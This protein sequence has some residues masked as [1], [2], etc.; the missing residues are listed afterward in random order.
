MNIPRFVNQ[1]NSE[2]NFNEYVAPANQPT[3]SAS[4][5]AIEAS[6]DRPPCCPYQP[7]IAEEEECEERR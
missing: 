3:Q 6:A 2:Q 7:A 1:K 4:Q 5:P